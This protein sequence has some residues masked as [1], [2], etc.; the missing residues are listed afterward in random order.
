LT[1]RCIK[2]ASSAFYGGKPIKSINQALLMIGYLEI[3]RVAFTV[4]V[5]DSF[6]RLKIKIDWKKY[7][8]HSILVGRLG[9]TLASAFRETNGTE[10]LAGLM[11]DMGKLVIEHNFPR[12]F[13]LV[14]LRSMERKCGHAMVERDLLGIDHTQIGAA[15]CHVM[16]VSAEVRNAVQFH[17]DQFS[18][19]G[20]VKRLHDKGFLAACISVADSLAN[21][22]A[23]SVD[24]AIA[25]D[26]WQ[27]LDAW[28]YLTENFN[29]VFGL[30]LDLEKAVENAQSDLDS[31][32]LAP[33]PAPAQAAA[34]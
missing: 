26:D 22:T 9:E 19:F 6:S 8:L 15:M 2:I 24:G 17:H 31:L 16:K 21:L 7:W 18:N 4:G 27:Q 11:H 23:A 13:E 25:T 20:A 30:D 12:E 10:Y 32:G 34:A 5:V 33:S 1:A 3:R 14:I 29:P 28:K